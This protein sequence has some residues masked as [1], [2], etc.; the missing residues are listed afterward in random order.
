M[1][2]VPA[3]SRPRKANAQVSQTAGAEPGSQF[4][5]HQVRTILSYSGEG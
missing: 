5:G 2:V 1:G 4:E 3:D